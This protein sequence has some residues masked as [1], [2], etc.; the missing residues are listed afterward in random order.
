[1]R[2]KILQTVG[3]FLLCLGILTGCGRRDE[4]EMVG[5]ALGMDLSE[6]RVVRFWDDHGGFHGDGTVF[7][8]MLLEDLV[9]GKEWKQ[10]PYPTEI[11]EFLSATENFFSEGDGSVLPEVT[12]GFY[13]FENRAYGAGDHFDPT[14]V[15]G[16]ASYNV[17]LAIYDAG[18]EV[19]YYLEVDT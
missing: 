11:E 3:I 16:Q 9:P 6:G 13:Y 1:M 19:L 18:A 8:E 5:R 2:R 12:E 4:K 15:N 10:L 14:G 17:T 7:C